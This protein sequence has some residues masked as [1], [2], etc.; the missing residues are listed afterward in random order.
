[1]NLV[2]QL[3][4]VIAVLFHL[5]AF[6]LESLLFSR[7]AVRSLFGVRAESA[8]AVRPWAYNQGFYNLLLATG[9]LAGLIAYHSGHPD[10]GRALA[11]YGC[12]FMTICGVVLLATDRRMWRGAVGQSAPPLLALA[13][14]MI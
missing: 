14:L 7:P 10:A 3:L 8:A 6:V 13:A 11:I 1:V 12:A 9:P 2:A 5:L 4:L